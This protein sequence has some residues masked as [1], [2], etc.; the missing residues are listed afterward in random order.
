M[1]ALQEPDRRAIGAIAFGHFTVDLCQGVVPALIPFLVAAGTVSLG[2]AG[3]LVF[4]VSACSS[5]VQPLFGAFADRASWRGLMPASLVLTGACLALGVSAGT[6]GATFALLLL[7]GIGV[8]AFHPE[9]ARGMH[10]AAGRRRALAMSVFS[11]GGALGYAAAPVAVAALLGRAGW[12]GLWLLLVPV[13]LSAALLLV[14][15]RREPEAVA[16]A[17]AAA[18]R[19]A[20]DWVGFGVLCVC[21]VTRSI[22]F[23]GMNTFLSVYMM[24]HWHYSPEAASWVTTQFLLAGI[25]GNLAGG[26]LA[27][28]LGRRAVARAGFGLALACLP[29]VLLAPDAGRAVWAAMAVSVAFFA[30]SAPLI[31]LGQEYLPNR[32]GTASGVTIGLAV[33][34]GGMVAP[35]LGRLADRAGVE[36]V[37]LALGGVLA[38]AALAAL[39]MPRPPVALDNPAPLSQIDPA[40]PAT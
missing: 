18:V 17:R 30:S 29:L 14:G 39:A 28:R 6:Y 10:R 11:V 4:A 32:V 36:A 5:L 24:R 35:L 37:L 3:G 16:R 8:A 2:A 38:A 15:V 22:V 23:F 40:D 21:V 13:A 25:V 7:C 33:S 34:V 27:D 1:G 9:A 20:D 19:P 12:D 31:V 26:A